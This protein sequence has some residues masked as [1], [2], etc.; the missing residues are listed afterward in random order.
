MSIRLWF[1]QHDKVANDPGSPLYDVG[2]KPDAYLKD[3]TGPISTL[4]V[5]EQYLY[6]GSWDCTVRVYSKETWDCVSVLAYDDW[7]YSIA[8]RGSQLL[9]SAGVAVC[10][11]DICTGQVTRKFENLHDGPCTCLEG[12]Q[13]GKMLFTGSA[14]GL[15]LAH[16]LRMK[17]PSMVLWHHNGA[18]QSLAFED[19]WMASAS[20]DGSVIMMNTEAQLKKAAGLA[21][22]GPGASGARCLNGNCRQFQAAGAAYA[23]DI[24]DQWLVCGSASEVVKVGFKAWDTCK[25]GGSA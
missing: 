3:H 8:A 13:N 21:K 16:D 4:S 19:P 18:V 2:G 17:D 6:S 5:D 11:H 7:V 9:V 20:A 1:S 14:D 23:V 15:V 22:A 24:R 10:V 25:Q 12:T